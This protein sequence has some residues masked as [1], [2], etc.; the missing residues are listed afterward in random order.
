MQDGARE[1]GSEHQRECH[2]EDD[3]AHDGTGRPSLGGEHL[4]DLGDGEQ[5]HDTREEEH[6][7][8]QNEAELQLDLERRADSRNP[9]LDRP[10]GHRQGP[11]EAGSHFAIPMRACATDLPIGNPTAKRARG[12]IRCNH[13]TPGRARD[14][15][16]RPRWQELS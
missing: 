1:D 3:E 13:G 12:P 6:A 4:S 5:T 15:E 8:D 9:A 14:D 11:T 7:D 10:E 2:R 16:P